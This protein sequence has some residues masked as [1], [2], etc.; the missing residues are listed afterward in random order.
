MLLILQQKHVPSLKHYYSVH[1]K[2]T[3]ATF[4]VHNLKDRGGGHTKHNTT[5]IFKICFS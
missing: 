4:T 2:L 5:Y 1:L 3:S